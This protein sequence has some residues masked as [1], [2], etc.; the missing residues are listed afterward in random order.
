ML[1]GCRKM[2]KLDGYN[3]IRERDSFSSIQWGSGKSRCPWKLADWAEEV[4]SISSQLGCSF[5]HILREA[6]DSQ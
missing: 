5:H 3:A 4:H 1:M 2:C 6:N